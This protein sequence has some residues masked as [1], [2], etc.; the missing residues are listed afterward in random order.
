MEYWL[1]NPV[2]ETI[3]TFTI[4]A[5]TSDYAATGLLHFS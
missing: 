4:D 3:K 2:R 1:V 5:D